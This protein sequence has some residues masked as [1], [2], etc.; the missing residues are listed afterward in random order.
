MTRENQIRIDLG[1]GERGQQRRA[2]L[3]QM[4]R[5]KGIEWGGYPSIGRMVKNM[6]DEYIE[7]RK[8]ATIESANFEL[9]KENAALMRATQNMT[10]DTR[11]DCW[12]HVSYHE[13]REDGTNALKA[14]TDCRHRLRDMDG[15]TV[16]CSADVIPRR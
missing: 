16:L 7:R 4:A 13:T 10:H 15:K 1:K 5:D 9:V 8:M 11:P 3:E 14:A 2:A 6:V 12:D